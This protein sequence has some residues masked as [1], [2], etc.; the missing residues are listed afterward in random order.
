M[1][2]FMGKSFDSNYDALLGSAPA[3]RASPV[4]DSA[5]LPLH[6]RAEI[7]RAGN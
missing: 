2:V 1:S 6:N 4:Y 7:F 3:A 5:V